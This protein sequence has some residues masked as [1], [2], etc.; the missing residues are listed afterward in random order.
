MVTLEN[1]EEYILLD[2]DGELDVQE[3]RE[4]CNFL[5]LHPALKREHE[6]Y[7]SIRAAPDYQMMYPSKQALMKAAPQKRALSGYGWWA[8]GMAACI[9]VLVCIS[10]KR[11][12]LGEYQ[13][14][15]SIS[16]IKTPE[17]S[18]QRPSIAQQLTDKSFHSSPVSPIASAKQQASMPEIP[19]TVP[20]ATAIKPQNEP[21]VSEKLPAEKTLAAAE[22]KPIKIAVITSSPYTIL[23]YEVP[24]PAIAAAII[25]PET[26]VIEPIKRKTIN[27]DDTA[28]G[29][30]ELEY[31][32][33][34]KVKNV[35]N[36]KN[37]LKDTDVSVKLGNKELFV[38][39]F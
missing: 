24:R 20:A 34:E 28:N 6:Q 37:K 16:Q 36:I 19:E 8:A 7:Q 11:D 30:K 13:A 5:K 14:A 1:Y 2:A 35:K 3:Q 22:N 17:A 23:E 18:P 12:T 25:V 15:H 9:A 26:P 33:T 31:A 39:K 4:L 38:L 27:D 32:L 21:G 29:L 10:V